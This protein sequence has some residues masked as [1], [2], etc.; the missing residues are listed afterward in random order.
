MYPFRRKV[1]AAVVALGW[2]TKTIRGTKPIEDYMT[3]GED[4]EDWTLSWEEEDAE[5]KPQLPSKG[6]HYAANP[7]LAEKPH[8]DIISEADVSVST[9]EAPS[10]ELGERFAPVP[11]P[12]THAILIQLKA[13]ESVYSHYIGCKRYF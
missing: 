7:A 5:V 12:A 13:G 3:G 10:A 11:S 9:A 1:P 8:L 2:Y 4:D 6:D